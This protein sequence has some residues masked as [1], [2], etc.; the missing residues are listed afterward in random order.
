MSIAK[1][2][3]RLFVGILKGSKKL[4]EH[5]LFWWLRWAKVKRR[6]RTPQQSWRGMQG[7]AARLIEIK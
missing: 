2:W 3:N 1:V 4:S 6:R 7:A 5:R